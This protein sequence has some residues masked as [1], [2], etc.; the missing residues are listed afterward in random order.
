M[1]SKK[2]NML[3]PFILAFALSS[4]WCSGQ[5]KIQW[6]TW[7]EA[8]QQRQDFIVQNQ[9]AIKAGK[10]VPKKIFIDMYTSWCGWC[11]KMD[12]STFLDPNVVRYMNEKFYPV[13]MNAE[14]LDTITY[15]GHIFTAQKDSRGKAT[16]MLAYSLLDGKMSYPTYVILDEN[17][18]RSHVIPGYKN[19]LEFMSTLV[20]FGSNEYLSYKDYLEKMFQIQQQKTSPK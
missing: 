12:A 7:Q 18:K 15:D 16:H 1:N 10:A 9:D 19:A 6:I 14:M 5:D 11:K 4:Q 3:Y 13:K 2:Q 20:F 8:V 17:M